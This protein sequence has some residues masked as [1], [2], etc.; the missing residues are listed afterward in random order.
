MEISKRIT[1][2]DYLKKVKEI[3][4]DSIEVKGIYIKK[5]LS[6]EH[7]CSVCEYG[8]NARPIDILKGSGCKKCSAKRVGEGKKKTHEDYVKEVYEK[9]NGEIEVIGLYEKNNKKIKHRCK[10]YGHEWETK[11]TVIITNGSGCPECGKE[12]YK[13]KRTKTHDDYIREIKEIHGNN[14]EVKEKYI[15]SRTNIKHECNVCNHEWETRPN[16]ILI[17]KTGCPICEIK[18]VGENKKKT[19]NEYV[20]EVK[21]IHK[22]NIEVIE[23][24]K[25]RVVKI[26]HKHKTCGHEWYVKP[27]HILEG[28]SCPKCNESRGERL[29]RNILE[30]L[31]VTFGSQV[32]FEELG[33]N[34][35]KQLTCDFVVYKDNEPMFVIEYNG[36]QHYE[37]I[38]FFGGEEGYIKTIKRDK[39]KRK[40]LHERGIQLIAIPYNET[41]EQ[42]KETITYFIK[43]HDIKKEQKPQTSTQLKLNI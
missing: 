31:G 30:S 15:N 43:L 1:H 16:N 35:R 38:D 20:K 32:R 5:K 28:H 19:H 25:S 17:N 3:H 34:K 33:F 40:M 41:D 36:K 26:K 23:E 8:W 39:T 21:E 24:Y 7:K 22:G 14:I 2:E 42:V 29:V 27:S 37:P 13:E 18:I 12:R 6:I 9:T 10:E 11:P 4:G